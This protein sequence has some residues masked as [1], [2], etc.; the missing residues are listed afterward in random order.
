M[1]GWMDINLIFPW[2]LDFTGGRGSMRGSF[3]VFPLN[4]SSMS[5]IVGVT[6]TI[7]QVGGGPTGVELAAEIHDLIREDLVKYF[8]KLKV[9]LNHS[10]L[11]T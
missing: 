1:D 5:M 9:S 11:T 4:C 8:P 7:A 10:S 3:R 6:F 2:I